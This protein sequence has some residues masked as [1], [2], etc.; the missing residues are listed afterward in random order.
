[1]ALLEQDVLRLDVAMHDAARVRVRQRVGDFVEDP[2]RIRD[3][4]LSLTRE[5]VP[6]RLALHVRHHVPEQSV[7]RTRGEHWQNVRV[8]EVRGDLDLALEARRA[9][10]FASSAGSTLITTARS[11]DASVARKTRLMPP[12]PS[13]RSIR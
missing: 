5:A 10:S 13:S 9:T 8:L 4:Q 12:A 2:G 1:M 7:A 3:G 11:S 6:E